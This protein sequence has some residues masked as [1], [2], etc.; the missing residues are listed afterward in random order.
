MIEEEGI[1]VIHGAIA[2]LKLAEVMV[3]CEGAG[4][5]RSKKTVP[6][7]V[8]EVLRKRD[9]IMV[10]GPGSYLVWCLVPPL[11]F[12]CEERLFRWHQLR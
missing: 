1:P 10:Q 3:D 4:P 8:M 11:P 7:D 9:T 5:W 12:R 2:A 6:Y